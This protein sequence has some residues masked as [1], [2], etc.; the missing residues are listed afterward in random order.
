MPETASERGEVKGGETN[1]ED[2]TEREGQRGRRDR[3]VGNNIK[4]KEI[5]TGGFLEQTQQV[6]LIWGILFCPYGQKIIQNITLKT[7]KQ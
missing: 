2:E 6:V 4:W 1:R 7:I 5:K 3:S